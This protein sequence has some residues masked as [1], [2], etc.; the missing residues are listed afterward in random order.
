[1]TDITRRSFNGSA[2]GSLLTL[3]LLETLFDTDAFA[4][5]VKPITAKWLGEL[6][7]AGLDVKGEKL[8]QVAWQDK[9]EE[10]YRQV[11]LPELLKFIDFEKLTKNLE[12]RDQGERSLRPMFPEVEGLPTDLVFGHQVFALK[13]GRSVVPHG[14]DNMATAFLVLQGDFHGRHY[15]RLEDEKDHIIVKPTIDRAFSVG[16]CSSV[17]DHKDNVHWFKATSDTAF[18]FNI[19]VLNVVAG[20]PS[21]RVYMDPNGEAISEGRIRARRIKSAEAYKLYG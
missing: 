3:S 15:D 12:F 21:G 13:K 7:Q 4:A 11:N 20:K 16:E 19:H 1:M 6:H 14:H 2:L 17:S 8:T 18:I 9:V 5:E 10:L